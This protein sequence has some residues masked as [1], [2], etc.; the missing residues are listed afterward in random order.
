VEI[1]DSGASVHLSPYRGDFS[2][3]TSIPPRTIHAAGNTTFTAIGRGDM[4]I[5]MP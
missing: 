1:Y 2:S 5:T 4:T 3:Y